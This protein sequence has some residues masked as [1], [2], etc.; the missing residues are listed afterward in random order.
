M[1]NLTTIMNHA[2]GSTSLKRIKF[3]R[4]PGNL[5]STECYEGYILEE[6]DVSEEE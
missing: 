5:E 2:L 1:S 6:D 4:D 3:K